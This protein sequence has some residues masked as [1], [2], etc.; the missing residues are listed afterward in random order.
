M[1]LELRR[2]RVFLLLLGIAVMIG[3]SVPAFMTAS[4]RTRQ[5]TPAEQKA[6]ENLRGMTRGGVLPAE[7]VVARIESEFPR[8][9]AAALA[10]LVRARIRINQKDFA[11]AASLLD[12]SVIG[13]YSTLGDYAL[14]MR[15]NALE[16]AGQL[17]QARVFY[18]QL[19]NDHPASLQ[20]AKAMPIRA[21]GEGGDAT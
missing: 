12:S 14:F 7:D 8:T 3:V 2:H 9:K 5:Q 16:Q 4:C 13:N 6:L 18:E 20:A 11:G 10:R 21:G 19:L 17:P 15:A 1:F